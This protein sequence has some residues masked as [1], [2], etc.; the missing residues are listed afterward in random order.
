M[1]LVIEAPPQDELLDKLSASTIDPTTN[2]VYHPQTNP[3]PTGD[4]T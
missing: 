3:V 4:K 1:Y 2:I